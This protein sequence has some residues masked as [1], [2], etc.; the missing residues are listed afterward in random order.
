MREAVAMAA[1]GKLWARLLSSKPCWSAN[2]LE[3]PRGQ[4]CDF[5]ALP[6]NIVQHWVES[7]A[8]LRAADKRARVEANLDR[9]GRAYDQARARTRKLLIAASVGQGSAAMLGSSD[10]RPGGA[11]LGD[12]AQ[13]K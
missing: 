5:L 6:A 7:F 10:L 3:A 13:V 11:F 4:E 1:R 2:V 12:F 8:A 9:D